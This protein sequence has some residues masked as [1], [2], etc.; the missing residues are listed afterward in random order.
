[1]K[2]QNGKFSGS[3]TVGHLKQEHKDSLVNREMEY[4]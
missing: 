3:V 2:N 4:E 1:L